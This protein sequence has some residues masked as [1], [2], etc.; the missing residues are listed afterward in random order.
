M[1]FDLYA[2]AGPRD[3]SPDA[4]ADRI[5]QWEARGGDPGDAPFEPSS[6]VAGFFREVERDNRGLPGFEI[7]ADAEPHTGRGPVWLQ[8]EPAPPA[9]IAAIRLPRGS[10]QALG[11]VLSDIYGVGTKF[12]LVVFNVTSGVI[13]EPLAEIAA[14]ASAIFWPHGAIRAAIAGGGGL[15]AAIAAYV[16]GI[17]IVSGLVMIVGLFLFLLTVVTFVS[18]VRKRRA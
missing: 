8:T 6:D 4:A 11:G 2:W 16:I 12:D 10:E 17:P 1:R 7:L 5:E 18:E 15:L 14:Y 9:H 3:L 13:H